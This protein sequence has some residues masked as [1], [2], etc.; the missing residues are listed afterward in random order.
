LNHAD[1]GI[2]IGGLFAIAFFIPVRDA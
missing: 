2:P 1:N